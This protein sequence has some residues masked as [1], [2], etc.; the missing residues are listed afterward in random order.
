MTSIEA[1]RNGRLRRRGAGFCLLAALAGS[2]LIARAED[3]PQ[4]VVPPKPVVLQ[5][6][7]ALPPPPPAPPA[8]QAPAVANKPGL[9]KAGKPKPTRKPLK[10]A[11][12][13]KPK[14]R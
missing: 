1:T 8:A 14:R 10:P 3:K 2:A 7:A 12:K 9:M 13:A 4:P 11:G 5:P 6:T